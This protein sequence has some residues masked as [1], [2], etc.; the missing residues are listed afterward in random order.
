MS[1]FVYRLKNTGAGSEKY[2]VCELCKK[3]ADSTYLL[4]K[5]RKARSGVLCNASD[6]FG[7]KECL[8]VLTEE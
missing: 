5:L 6:A 1:S 2:G 4:V 7:H 8:S 3:G